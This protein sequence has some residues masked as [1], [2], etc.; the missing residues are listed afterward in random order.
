MMLTVK[1]VFPKAMLI[2]D[3]FHVQQLVTEA[4]GQIRIRYRW[5]VLDAENK[6]VREHRARRKAV[7]TRAE[8]DLIGEWEPERME[9]QTGAGIQ[10]LP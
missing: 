1:T 8:K 9:N 6:A 7:H 4:I 10:H 3:R 5:E 2:S